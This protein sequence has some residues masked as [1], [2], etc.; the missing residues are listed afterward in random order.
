MSLSL[1]RF[2][3]QA[4]RNCDIVPAH[5]GPKSH[6][7]SSEAQSRAREVRRSPHLA[8]H[9]AS[10]PIHRRLSIRIFLPGIN[11]KIFETCKIGG[12]DRRL[13]GRHR[14]SSGSIPIRT[15]SSPIFRRRS[16]RSRTRCCTRCAVMVFKTRPMPMPAIAGAG[17]GCG[18]A[19]SRKEQFRRQRFPQR[20]DGKDLAWNH[21]ARL[22]HCRRPE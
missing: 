19:R 14:R 21:S 15:I 8:R 11:E 1:P 3:F 4:F 13:F 22:R 18:K 2:S 6:R 12:N 17:I 16:R 5:A 9:L 10:R 20:D 7:K